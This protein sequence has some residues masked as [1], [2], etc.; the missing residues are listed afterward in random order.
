MTVMYTQ[1]DNLAR[2]I[3]GS[4]LD[5]ALDTQDTLHRSGKGMNEHIHDEEQRNGDASEHS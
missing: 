4:F 1:Q 3:L 2:G 5:N